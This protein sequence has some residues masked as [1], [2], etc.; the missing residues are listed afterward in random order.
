MTRSIRDFVSAKS[1]ARV[2]GGALSPAGE[3]CLASF[4]RQMVA[5]LD[6]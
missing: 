6:D 5:T 1:L 2:A 3:S 4:Y